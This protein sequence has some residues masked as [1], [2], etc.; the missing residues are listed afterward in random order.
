M[1]LATHPCV[2]AVAKFR[3]LSACGNVKLLKIVTPYRFEVT[4]LWI[5]RSSSLKFPRDSAS[6]K[7]GK[8]KKCI[9]NDTKKTEYPSNTKFNNKLGIQLYVLW[10]P[11]SNDWYRP[12]TAVLSW[13]ISLYEIRLRQYTSIADTST[14]GTSTTGTGSQEELWTKSTSIHRGTERPP[15]YQIYEYRSISTT[16]IWSNI[17]DWSSTMLNLVHAA[18][19]VLEN[20][21]GGLNNAMALFSPPVR[22]SRY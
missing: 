2:G 13:K 3:I 17:H 4:S 15:R 7:K 10:L 12:G 21:T 19:V 8:K 22:F 1:R 9:E 20:R 5:D 6:K 11:K 14:A 16:G 18:T